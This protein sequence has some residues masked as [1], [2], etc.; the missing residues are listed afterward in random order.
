[1]Q[2]RVVYEK[3]SKLHSL[4][5]SRPNLTT[6]SL[7]RIKQ[8]FVTRGEKPGNY[9]RHLPKMCRLS[10]ALRAHDANT[11]GNGCIHRCGHEERVTGGGQKEH[12]D[13]ESSQIVR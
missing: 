3:C 7:S 12:S 5:A 1:M 11:T 4:A 8:M 9:I 2:C 10:N 6:D 13:F